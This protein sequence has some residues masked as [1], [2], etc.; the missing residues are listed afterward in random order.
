[1]LCVVMIMTILLPQLG[2]IIVL[3]KVEW[4][5]LFRLSNIEWSCGFKKYEERMTRVFPFFKPLLKHLNSDVFF[6]EQ[7]P[8]PNSYCDFLL[9]AKILLNEAHR[10]YCHYDS[11][12]ATGL[13][14]GAMLFLLGSQ[15]LIM[16]ASRCLCCGRALKPGRSRACAI[17][18][19]ITCWYLPNP[20]F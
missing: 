20:N 14:A 7:S 18:L 3:G 9:Q 6:F 2:G 4:S 10:N 8:F 13:G 11:D 15:L 17:T 5:F 16:V 19:F 1:M 12:I